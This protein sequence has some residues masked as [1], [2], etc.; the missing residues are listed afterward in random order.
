MA[1]A[2]TF[3][4]RVADPQAVALFPGSFDDLQSKLVTT[5]KANL[6]AQFAS[7][8]RDELLP[9]QQDVL[10]RLSGDDRDGEAVMKLLDEAEKQKKEL[11]Q[12][13]QTAMQSLLRERAEQGRW[14][15]EIQAFSLEGF[16]LKDTS[17]IEDLAKMTR[18]IIATKNERVRGELAV[19]KAEADKLA[20]LKQTEAETH[21]RIERAR[22]EAEAQK[23]VATAAAQAEAASRSIRLDIENRERKERAEAE[24]DAIRV[25]AEANYAKAVKEA[26]A[27][28]RIPPQHVELE[29]AR[30]AVAGLEKL[31]AAAWRL[32]EPMLEA[33]EAL[34]PYMRVGGMT[35]HDI[36]KLSQGMGVD[37]VRASP[38]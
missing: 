10:T 26:E 31:G 25:L 15:I 23:H 11:V 13:I 16:E 38:K 20:S 9:T 21:V 6:Q 7:Y 14:G 18:S 4:W 33:L 35:M 30:L 19:A 37:S 8:N 1:V 17:V 28:S 36:T 24:A 22:A 32:P 12:E 29:R 3:V 5:A 2:V 34:K 27:A